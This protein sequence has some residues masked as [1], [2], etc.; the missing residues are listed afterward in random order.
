MNV[1]SS[2]DKW[3]C[4]LLLA[5]MENCLH[6]AWHISCFLKGVVQLPN[7]LLGGIKISSS[8]V[9]VKLVF[10]DSYCLRYKFDPILRSF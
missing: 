10:T 3:K 2:A 9:E 6:Y 5:K 7:R 4:V 1:A 8:R